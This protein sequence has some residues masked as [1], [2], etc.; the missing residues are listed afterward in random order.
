M[1]VKE[2]LRELIESLDED[3]A[4]EALSFVRVLVAEQGE[5]GESDTAA[6][7]ARAKPFTFDDPL[8][9]IVG[10]GSSKEPTNVAEHK[11]DYLADAVMPPRE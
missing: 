4:A 7:L 5:G 3:A 10:I 1:T 2:E 11:D 9:G 6:I 8:W